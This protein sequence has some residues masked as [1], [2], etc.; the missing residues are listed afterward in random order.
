MKEAMFWKSLE[1]IAVQCLLC[2]RECRIAD[3]KKGNCRV[4]KNI[5]GTLY[6]LNYGM[7]VSTAIDPIEKKPLF[8]FFPGSEILSIATVGC[9][10][11]CRFCQNWD[12]SQPDAIIGEGMTP[13][14]VVDIAIDRGIKLIAYTYTEPTIFFEFA[15]DTA[16]LA[17]KHG[18]KNVFVTNGYINPEP[19]KKIAPYL[20]AVNIDLKSMS[21]TFYQKLCGAKGV[22]PVLETIKLAHKLNIHIEITNLL[23][24]GWNTSEAQ[25]T[26]LCRW[27]ADLDK[28]IPLHF[29]R[30]FPV[31]KMSVEPTPIET[32]EIA[33]KIGKA[34]G[35]EYVY[36]GNV[37]VGKENTY[38]PSCNALIIE[39]DAGKRIKQNL[40]KGK[41]TK[42]GY[43][44]Y[45]AGFL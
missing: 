39:R 38:C 4:R 25:I 16:K 23:I 35:I 17:H 21:D 14:D 41:C 30:Y 13:Q 36:L 19:L 7:I 29:S 31:Y 9:N 24:P 1:G 33:Y 8:H 34:K 11:H 28:K 3:G 12:I 6:S 10:F 37:S 22:G 2:P 26:E 45:G 5:G 20:D 32:L 18:I 40:N 42:C 43:N 27:V 44:I 15:Y